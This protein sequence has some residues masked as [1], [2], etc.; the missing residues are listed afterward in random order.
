MKE[1]LAS[2]SIKGAS[3]PNYLYLMQR[4]HELP[5]VGDNYGL[6]A[7]GLCTVVDVNHHPEHQTPHITVELQTTEEKWMQLA[8]TG[9]WVNGD[10]ERALRQ[11]PLAA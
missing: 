3:K 5:R 11:Q 9:N 1:F 4:W 10:S 7:A 8:A 2:V 6:R